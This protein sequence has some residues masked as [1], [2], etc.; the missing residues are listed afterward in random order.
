[1]R[2]SVVKRGLEVS[3]YRCPLCGCEVMAAVDVKENEALEGSPSCPVCTEKMDLVQEHHQ[4]PLHQ[5][6]EQKAI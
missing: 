4:L 6:V 1:M 2:I 5:V 3:H